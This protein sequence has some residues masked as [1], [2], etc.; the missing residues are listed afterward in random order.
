MMHKPNVHVDSVKHKQSIS[1]LK[2]ASV[3][4]HDHYKCQPTRKKTMQPC[5]SRGSVTWLS[6]A[7]LYMA[8]HLTYLIVSACSDS[9][10]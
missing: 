10:S 6:N 4:H 3:K 2:K 8:V 1:K 9:M 5:V 7:K